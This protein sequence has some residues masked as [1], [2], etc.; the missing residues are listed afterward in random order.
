MH[1]SGNDPARFRAGIVRHILIV[2]AIAAATSVLQ[3]CSGSAHPAFFNP[4]PN[5][6]APADDAGG[7]S[8]HARDCADWPCRKSATQGNWSLQ[9]R[10]HPRYLFL[11]NVERIVRAKHDKFRVCQ[12]HRHSHGMAIGASVVTATM[13]Q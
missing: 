9:R 2:A 12:F 10:Y 7:N 1:R 6:P 13:G 11:C 3:G 4:T 5:S 8:D